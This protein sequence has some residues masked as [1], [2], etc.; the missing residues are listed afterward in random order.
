MGEYYDIRG[1]KI[2]T[3]VLGESQN[4]ALLFIHGGPGGIG[5]EDFI[6][7]AG[8]KLAENFRV[9]AV[10][11]RG[12]WRSEGLRDDEK[13]TLEDIIE[14]F[15][16]LRKQLGI[17]KW[18][19]LSHSFGGY[20]SVLYAELYPNSIVNI[21]YENPSFDFSLSERSMLKN[22]AMELIRLGKK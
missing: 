12:V 8:E 5:C 17:E 18:S 10:D 16:E 4:P 3:E 13:I 20:L 14:D 1:K 6:K 21:I 2:Y 19:L 7:Y 15:E 9:V 22:A 11:Q